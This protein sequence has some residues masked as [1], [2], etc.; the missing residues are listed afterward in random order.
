[1]YNI[2]VIKNLV[3]GHQYIDYTELM[4]QRKWKE[5]LQ[6][7]EQGNSPLFMNM[8]YYG[9]SNFKISILE[10]FYNANIEERMEYWFDRYNPELNKDVLEYTHKERRKPKST[11]KWGIQ[12][13][14]KPKP[15]HETNTIKCRCVET[16]K[17]KTL[18][19][20][21]AAAEFAGGSVSNIK[22][23][24][25]RKG[26]AY[27][28]KW[29]IFKKAKDG[30]RRVYGVHKDGHVTPVFESIT[31]AMRAMGEEDRGKGICTS[32]KWNLRWKGYLW[33]YSD[34]K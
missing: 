23:A 5:M 30:K 3:T 28:Y 19:G 22:K 32:I 33:Y 29:W 26:T 27:G 4:L 20:W 9:V 11:R 18:H 34:D 21:K 13:K 6:K 12:R 31:A 10:E 2:Y 16:G 24:V 1:M 15:R 14:H 25:A 17:L 8:K 7:H